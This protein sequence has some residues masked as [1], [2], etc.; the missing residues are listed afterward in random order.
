[1]NSP[2]DSL[3]LMKLCLPDMFSRGSVLGVLAP[4]AAAFCRSGLRTHGNDTLTRSHRCQTPDMRIPLHNWVFR[5]ILTSGINL[6]PNQV[7]VLWH[8]FSP[9]L[10]DCRF[11]L[12]ALI[13]T[14]NSFC[15]CP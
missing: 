14:Q 13:V 10:D 8:C 6:R 4:M 11:E 2:V 3:H 15:L 7:R 5:M 1:M 9:F 12:V